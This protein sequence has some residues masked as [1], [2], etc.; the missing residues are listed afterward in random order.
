MAH[1]FISLKA[2]AVKTRISALRWIMALHVKIPEELAAHGS[3]LV[4]ALLQTLKDKE[5]RVLLLGLEALS[6]ISSCSQES[7][8][9]P[10]RQEQVETIYLRFISG[11]VTLLK[12]N[13]ALSGDRGNFT[14]QQLASLIP[15][16]RLYLQLARAV[17]EEESVV[18]ARG[19]I[20]KLNW[21]LLTA[22]EL[23][24]L[25]E[26]LRCVAR[27]DNAAPSSI[28]SLCVYIDIDIDIYI[29][30]WV[31]FIWE[32]PTHSHP[33]PL[34]SVASHRCQTLPLPM[35]ADVRNCT[36]L[37]SPHSHS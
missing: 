15:P 31:T 19:V 13:Q 10:R 23:K 1:L 28:H 6:E 2:R 27:R 25:R 37:T 17:A 3:L 24:G 8:P 35:N 36:A 30:G 29:R 4:D 5:D 18:L 16:Y 9:S 7:A 12:A 33:F 21:I 34:E 14:V 22:P 26:D 11:L 32:G 20:R